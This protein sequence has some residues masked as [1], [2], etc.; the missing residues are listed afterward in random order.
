LHGASQRPFDGVIGRFDAF[1]LHEHKE[2]FEVHEQR[3]RQ[4]P[5][6][7][8]FAVDIADGQSAELFSSGMAF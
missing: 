2:P 5:Y 4:I 7:L 6:V 1:F 3:C 8:V